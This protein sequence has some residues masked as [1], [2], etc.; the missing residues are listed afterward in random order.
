MSRKN[1]VKVASANATP[2]VKRICSARSIGKS[3][4]AGVGATP[5]I[6]SD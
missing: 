1:D 3:S 6:T 4:M 2:D 5:N